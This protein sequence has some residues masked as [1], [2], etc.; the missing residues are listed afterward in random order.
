VRKKLDFF[1]GPCVLESESLAMTIA[2]TIKKD[3]E[4]VQNQINLHFKGSFDKA[5]RSSIDS[6]RGPGIDEG[7]RILEKVKKEFNLPIITDFHYPDQAETVARVADTLQIPAFLCRQTDMIVAGALACKKHDRQLKIK[8]GQFLAPEDTIN[9]IKKAETH[10]PLNKILITERGT[11]FGYQNLIVDMASFQ[12][13]QNFGVRVIHDAT[14]CVQRP[15]GLGNMTGG[16][17]E[18]VAVL[19]K[20]AIA[21]GA[22][23]IFIETH[24]NPEQAL[25][26]KTT[27]LDIVRVKELVTVLVNIHKVVSE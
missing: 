26:D 18:Q 22:D 11:S 23:G 20:A 15:G 16:K 5:N 10:L 14:H 8:K 13:I 1:I 4:P 24:T 7:L 12:I 21:A 19:A 25:C 3:L 27:C 9:I 2:E 17:R 6:Y